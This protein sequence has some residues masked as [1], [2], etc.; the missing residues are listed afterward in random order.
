[1]EQDAQHIITQVESLPS[2]IRDEFDAIDARAR[3]LLNHQEC[4]SLKRIII[5]GCGDSYMA[6]I[7]TELGIEQLSGIPVEPMTAIQAGRYASSGMGGQFPRSELIIGISVSGTVSR[8]REALVLAGKAG[9]VTVAMTAHPDSPLAKVAEKRFDCT[10]APSV[11]APGVRSYRVSL[12]ALYLLGIHLAEVNGRMTQDQAN[13]ERAKLRATAEAIESTIEISRGPAQALAEALKDKANFVFTGDGPHYATALF[14]AAKII[15]ASGRHA[16][17]QDTE[18]WAHLQF[19]VNVEA[20]TP[21]FFI[22]PGYRGH[23]RS[24]EL[25]EVAGKIGRNVIGIIPTNDQEIAQFAHH[26]LPVAGETP[27]IYTPM[28]YAVPGELF[29]AYLS[30][31]V[32]EPPFRGFSGVYG[33][34]DNTIRTSAVMESLD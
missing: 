14:S 12:M 20:D 33:A 34:N 8:T 6:G 5:T 30:Q 24:V 31:A 18:E 3:T 2:M 28:T 29:S 17:G 11:P 26:V 27:E 9:A 23:S 32:G 1:M 25:A 22:S 15:E 10:V 16:M 4:L 13:A 21:T 19:F 7:A